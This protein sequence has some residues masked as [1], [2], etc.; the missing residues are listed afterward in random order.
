M[1]WLSPLAQ[2]PQQRFSLWWPPPRLWLLPRLRLPWPPPLP[3]P[4]SSAFPHD[5]P[6]AR[7]GLAPRAQYAPGAALPTD[8]APHLPH[9]PHHPRISLTPVTQARVSRVVRCA[10][11]RPGRGNATV[12]RT[13]ARGCGQR[14]LA[15]ARASS[16]VTP[17]AG[18]CS[19]LVLGLPL[20]K[21]A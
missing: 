4:K 3:S 9:L 2:R 12:R 8:R 10:R 14:A 11:P 15:L 5:P 1:H 18:T 19:T 6:S 7:A 16:D 21:V 17:P 20:R 13:R